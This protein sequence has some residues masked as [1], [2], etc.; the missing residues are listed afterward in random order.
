[1]SNAALN[2]MVRTVKRRMHNGE[3]LEDILQSYPK[4]TV[5]A[6]KQVRDA[7]NSQTTG[8]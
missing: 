6:A 4:L 2:L 3:N 7:V 5:E 1:M 8:D